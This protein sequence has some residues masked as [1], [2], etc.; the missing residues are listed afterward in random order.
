MLIA[1]DPQESQVGRDG[2]A[3]LGEIIP[4]WPTIL[5]GL[6]GAATSVEASGDVTDS[7]N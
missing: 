7:E 3:L 2:I 5:S 4:A 6:Q 1:G